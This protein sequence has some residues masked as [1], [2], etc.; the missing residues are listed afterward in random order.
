[1]CLDLRS[2]E[3]KSVF[4]DLVRTADFV[5]ENYRPGTLDKMGLGPDELHELNPRLIVVHISGYG[6][7]G[8]WSRR[9]LFN[10]I[11]EATAGLMS[12]SNGPAEPLMSGN[13]SADHA[14]GQQAL[15]AA[16]AALYE[17]ERSGEGQHLDI[18][19]FDA[20]VAVLGFP[21][22]AALND[23]EVVRPGGNRDAT[24]AP[25]NLFTAADGRSLYI[26]AGTDDLFAAL[27]S[28]MAAAPDDRF[29]TIAGRDENVDELEA[30]IGAWVG[31]LPAE[32][33]S[34]RLE[35]A[36]VPHGIVQTLPEVVRHPLME[37]RDLI[38]EFPG[39]RDGSV[40]RVPGVPVKFGRTPG[41]VRLP[42]PTTGEH[43][44]EILG[45]LG[46]DDAGIARLR[47]AGAV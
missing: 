31:S 41:G 15:A 45:E 10:A 42:P 17:R 24:A 36:G 7:E 22:T 27:T 6:Q 34:R 25:G 43:T 44:D 2:D 3:G 21:L 9:P 4:R 8:P 13:F 14:A 29:G 19:L 11:A 12:L 20:T 18:A 35:D 28:A 5:L 30:V 39:R 32:E 37:Q 23:V 16:L 46:Y 1:M 33:V 38:A 26:D 40:L 47:E